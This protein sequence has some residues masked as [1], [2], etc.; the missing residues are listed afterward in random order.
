MS[1]KWEEGGHRL[2]LLI[3]QAVRLKHTDNMKDGSGFF[4]ACLNTILTWHTLREFLVTVINAIIFSALVVKRSPCA[5]TSLKET[6]TNSLMLRSKAN[7][8][9]QQSESVKSS[10]DL[11]PGSCVFTAGVLSQQHKYCNGLARK[12]V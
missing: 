7:M 5:V 4:Q 10:E 11:S 12:F 9:P 2:H 8:R 1:E 6:E 3:R